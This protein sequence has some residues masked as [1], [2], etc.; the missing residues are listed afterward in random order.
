MVASAS[1]RRAATA[2]GAGLEDR[3]SSG[4]SAQPDRDLGAA[5]EDEI[6]TGTEAAGE[7]VRSESRELAESAT[8]ASDSQAEEIKTDHPA[9][10]ISMTDA[11]TSMADAATGQP[12]EDSDPDAAEPPPDLEVSRFEDEG[13]A[14]PSGLQDASTRQSEANE[15]EPDTPI[16]TAPP[17]IDRSVPEPQ[18]P[19]PTRIS[20][21]PPVAAEPVSDSAAT[22]EES[23]ITMDGSI[24]MAG[25]QAVES[26]GDT[27]PAQEPS[28]SELQSAIPRHPA[29]EVSEVVAGPSHESQ[30]QTPDDAGSTSSDGPQ[31]EPGEG[32]VSVQD[33]DELTVVFIGMEPAGIQIPG[34]DIVSVHRLSPLDLGPIVESIKRTSK[35]LIVTTPVTRSIG[36]NI[37]AHISE[38]LEDWLDSDVEHITVA[39]PMTG[40]S[41]IVKAASDLAEY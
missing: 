40:A 10:T 12:Q 21:D 5:P 25:L 22:V 26:E 32:T 15:V 41:T 24:S 30:D 7:P 19:S 23:S 17:D 31:Q 9:G 35:P 28:V 36:D 37:A 13:L 33:G 6:R 16:E 8:T 27:E 1:S 39:N 20:F 34:G 29:H 3:R 18:T 14:I 38:K 2:Q 11:A 4:S